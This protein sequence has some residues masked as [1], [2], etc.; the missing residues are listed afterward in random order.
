MKDDEENVQSLSDVKNNECDDQFQ[1]WGCIMDAEGD[2]N[3][4]KTIVKPL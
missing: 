1:W 4:R 2:A 3:D